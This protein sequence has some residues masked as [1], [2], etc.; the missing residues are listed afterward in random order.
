M[1]IGAILSVIIYRTITSKR[2]QS[3]AKKMII[4]GTII[5]LLF[6]TPYIYFDAMDIKQSAVRQPFVMVLIM[7]IFR[8]IEGKNL[9]HLSMGYL[10]LTHF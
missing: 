8:T 1:L 10:T 5:A 6:V 7:L 9:Q 2:K 3:L 4:A